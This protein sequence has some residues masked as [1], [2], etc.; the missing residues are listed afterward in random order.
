MVIK[1]L[2]HLW[3]LREKNLQKSMS[4]LLTLKSKSRSYMLQCW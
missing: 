3:A 1:Q 2:I 4:V